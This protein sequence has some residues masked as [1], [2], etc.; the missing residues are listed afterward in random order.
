MKPHVALKLRQILHAPAGRNPDQVNV[1]GNGRAQSYRAVHDR[2]ARHGAVLAAHQ[3]GRG[4][5]V[6]VM[7]WDRP[8]TLDCFSAIPMVGATLHTVN[9]RLSSEQITSTITHAEDDAIPC[10]EDFP[11][12]LLPLL[13]PIT[14]PLKLI[15][16]ADRADVSV[17]EGFL[18]EYEVLIADHPARVDLP[19]L[20]EDTGATH[21]STTGTTGDPKG[22]SD[23]HRQRVLHTLAVA[24]DLGTVPEAG[25]LKRDDVN[26]P[27]TSPFHVHGCGFPCVA[28]FLGLTRVYPGRYEP[29]RR[30][31]LIGEHQVTVSHCVPTILAVAL[32]APRAGTTDLTR[33]KLLIG[34]S[35]LTEGLARQ[36]WARGIE[37]HA[38]NGLSETCPFVTYA[39]L[40]ASQSSGDVTIRTASERPAPRVEVR[41]VGPDMAGVPKDGTGTG[42]VIARTPWLTQGDLKND[43]ATADVWPGGWLHNRRCRACLAR[44][45]PVQYPPAQGRDQVGWRMGVLA[46]ARE[47][48]LHRAGPG[49]GRRRRRPGPP[50]GERPVPV[51]GMDPTDGVEAGNRQ[52]IAVAIQ[53]GAL[54]K[55]AAPDRICPVDAL[56]R[57]SVGK[58]DKKRIRQVLRTGEIA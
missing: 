19:A 15:L 45:H 23:S 12:I 21:L 29:A 25:G 27:V 13:P 56:P 38:A 53:G 50:P 36:A 54:P 57:I 30:L 18:G 2:I 3:L 6:A 28:T 4:K 17:P 43:N 32:A 49:Q 37:E 51:A 22:V 16:L 42:E 52:R 11:P 1:D 31:A 8:R 14:R 48:G 39:D 55:W 40:L 34:G 5:T 58:I 26:L 44:R 46:D 9:L 47:P 33:R 41:V 20:P 24:A 7:D 35:A 10:H